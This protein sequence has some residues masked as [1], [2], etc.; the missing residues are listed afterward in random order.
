MDTTNTLNWKKIILQY[1]RRKLES[2][3]RNTLSYESIRRY[4]NGD[5]LPEGDNLKNLTAWAQGTL[6][7]KTYEIF[8]T[9][10]T[11]D[12]MGVDPFKK[13]VNE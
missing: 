6:P 10:L 7:G 12:I 8:I 2:D 11:I 4:T 9:T 1:G 3:L 5:Q 13:A